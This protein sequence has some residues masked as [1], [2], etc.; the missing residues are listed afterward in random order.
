MR[1]S[2]KTEDTPACIVDDCDIRVEELLNNP[3]LKP[4]ELGEARRAPVDRA[5]KE[6]IDNKLFKI[7]PHSTVIIRV[8]TN[9][10]P[11]E[12]ANTAAKISF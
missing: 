4:A 5:C 6:E 12:E 2:V 9:I 11:R 3:E 8:D 10:R 7:P 1:D